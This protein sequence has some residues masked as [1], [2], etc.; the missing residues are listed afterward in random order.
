MTLTKYSCWDCLL[1]TR[2]G[3]VTDELRVQSEEEAEEQR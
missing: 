3:G 2:P 1:M